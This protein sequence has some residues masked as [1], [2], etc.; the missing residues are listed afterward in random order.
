LAGCFGTKVQTGSNESAYEFTVLERT[1]E[2]R[3][4]GYG[5][6]FE[7]GTSAAAAEEAARHLLPSDTATIEKFTDHIGGS[8]LIWNVRS[9]TLGRWFASPKVGDPAGNM[10]IVLSTNNPSGEPE[11]NPDNVNFAEVGLGVRDRNISC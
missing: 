9:P 1:P 11:Y 8:C 6:S 10:S 3:V 7:H 2:G 5:Q 4:D